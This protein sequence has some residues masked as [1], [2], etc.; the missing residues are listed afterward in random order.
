[1][2]S[3]TAASIG[4]PPDSWDDDSEKRTFIC[5]FG[6]A[7][8][9]VLGLAALAGIALLGVQVLGNRSG[10]AKV[11]QF[12]MVRLLPP[13]PPVPTPPPTPTEI[14]P[15]PTAQPMIEQ[16]QMMVPETNPGGPKEPS[17]KSPKADNKPSGPLGLNAKGEGS[18]DAFGLVG[19][20]G[21]NALLESG[22]GNGDGGGGGGGT[23]WGWYAGQ[24]Q[25]RVED[26]LRKN[27]HTRSAAFRVEVRIWTDT[28]GRVTR[29]QL[30]GS[31]GNPAVDAAIKEE[32][33]TGLQLQEPPPAD[34]PLPIVMRLTARRPN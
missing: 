28:T 6:F 16:K 14:Q 20:P 21:G 10:P 34:M 19:R 24:V 26:A 25:A 3:A 33:L 5:R 22:G 1:M 2:S 4:R 30:A 7:L 11:Q 27:P 8:S 12:K 9:F 17:D 23:R 13:P 32:V 15:Q 29:V 31:T 18:S